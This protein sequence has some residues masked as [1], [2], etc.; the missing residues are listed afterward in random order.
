[1]NDKKI[2]IIKTKKQF[3]NKKILSGLISA[4]EDVKKGRYFVLSN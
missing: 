1:M 2:K 3:I 4:L